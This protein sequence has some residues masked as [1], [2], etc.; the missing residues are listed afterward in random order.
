MNKEIRELIDREIQL[1]HIPGAVLTISLKDQIIYKEAFG[2]RTVYPSQKEMNIGTMFDLASLTKIVA[3][4]PAVLTLI[5]KGKLLLRDKISNFIPD[6]AQNNKEDITIFHLLTHTSGL[7]AHRSFYIENLTTDQIIEWICNEQLDAPVGQKVIY[8]DLGFI[9]LYKIIEITAQQPFP[10]FVK[11]EILEPL[12]MKNTLFCPADVTNIAAT[13]FCRRRNQ[14]KLGIVHDDNTDSMGG[15]SGHAGL[16][17]T[18]EDLSKFARM[19]ENNGVY[20]GNRLFSEAIMRLTKMNHTPFAN[21]FRGLGWQLQHRLTASCGELFTAKSY[22]HTGFTG[23]SIWFD[24]EIKLYVIFLTNRVHF[25]R[26]DWI[27]RLRPVL[28]NLIRS[29]F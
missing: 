25:G 19:I 1:A 7:P 21:D 12:E 14:Y 8:S 26:Q 27:L 24:P 13:E 20:E 15:I 3:T 17:S 18:A 5:E 2:Y 23:T 4:L 29:Q 28:H 9:L 11:R 16:F 22:G 6:F 10:A